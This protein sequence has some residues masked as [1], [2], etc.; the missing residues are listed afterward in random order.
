[1]QLTVAR[2]LHWVKV[3]AIS[4]SGDY[5]SGAFAV[6]KRWRIRFRL[7]AGDIGFAF[8][9]V[10]WAPDGDPFGGTG[11]TAYNSDRLRT[12]VVPA[13]GTYRLSIS[14]Y[15]GAAWHLEVD[16]LK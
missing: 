13:P 4:G 16:A 5:Q 7:A 8:A 12:Y 14:P 15:L 3:F 9:R 1:M 6:P 2:T 10:G 11:F